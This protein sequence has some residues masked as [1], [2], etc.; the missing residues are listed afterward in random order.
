MHFE[1]YKNIIV[2]IIVGVIFLLFAVFTLKDYS[3]FWDGRVHFERGYAFLNYYLTGKEG[4]PGAPVTKDFTR[5]VRDFLSRAVPNVKIVLPPLQTSSYRKSIYSLTIDYLL[6]YRKYVEYSVGHP[7]FSDIG[8]AVFNTIFYEKLG[9][10]RDD[11]AF[12][13]FAAFVAAILV[14]VVFF[15]SRRLFGTFSAIISSLTLSSYPLFWAESHFN[16][17]D[18]PEAAFFSLAI[19][20][21]WFA[22]IKKSKKWI[23]LS[24]VFAGCAIATKFNAF[25]LFPILGLWFI[26]MPTLK[27]KEERKNY[28]KLWWAI[29]LF[30]V[31]MLLMLFVSY[32]YL[33]QNPIENFLNVLNFYKGIGTA[34]DYTPSFRILGGINTYAF[35]WILYSTYPLVLV[36][37]A[38]GTVAAIVNLF[39]N[40]DTVPFLFVLWLF[41]TIGRVSIPGSSIYGGV[42]QIMEYIPPLSLLAGYGAYVLTSMVKKKK[43][44]VSVAILLLFIPLLLDIIKYHPAE[45][46]YFNSLIGGLPGAKKANITQWGNTYGSI[47]H[48]GVAW[49]NANASKNSHLA[50]AFGETAD[51]YI[52]ELRDDIHADQQFSGDFQKG[53]YVIG[54]THNSELEDTYRLAYLN[55]Y[56]NPVYEF[57]VDG[58]AL[59]KI[60]KNDVSHLKN[61]VATLQK[62]TIVPKVKVNGT[63]ITW[64][65]GKTYNVTRLT[66]DYKDTIG[67]QPL[68]V[69]YSRISLD[70]TNWVR[71][72]IDT[73]PGGS[74]DIIP[75]QPDSGSFLI[76]FALSRARYISL[77]FGPQNSCIASP[78]DSKIFVLE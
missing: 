48:E 7:P 62:S 6:S 10:L 47:Y 30:P 32:P 36:L 52:P 71:E 11:H 73:F 43:L 15:W 28:R 57:K 74:I 19:F 65:L 38:V 77:V 37:G 8:A 41:I 2:A 39:K 12:Q 3:I 16:T 21:F 63:I 56:L 33:W 72:P 51:F 54:L 78:V 26:L 46:A 9:I 75:N 61:Q 22:T 40:K 42:R 1:K 25:S 13:F 55:T 49:L 69:A 44:L 27:N 5:Y 31:V 45:N 68:N 64:D 18:I 24:S 4:T 20:A 50:T 66:F 58:V 60:W 59:L 67:C 23:L 35:F 14:G 17:K 70:G 29:L 34:I 76:P 53:E